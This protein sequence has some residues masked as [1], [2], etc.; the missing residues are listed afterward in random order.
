MAGLWEFPGGKVED[1]EPFSDALARELDEELGIEVEI[2]RPV[3]FAIHAEP[4]LE[5]LLLF[6]SA[7]ISDGVPTSREGQEIK[8]VRPDE[9][10]YFQMPPADDEVVEMLVSRPYRTMVGQDPPYP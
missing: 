4:E 10:K 3:T 8:W 7:S 9:L 5:I 6:F 2:G 1:G